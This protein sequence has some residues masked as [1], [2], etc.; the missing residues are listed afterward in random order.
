MLSRSHARSSAG[1]TSSRQQRRGALTTRCLPSSCVATHAGPLRPLPT[2]ASTP[3]A[4]SS[5]SSSPAPAPR[6]LGLR[7][8]DVLLA[9]LPFLGVSGAGAPAPA[10]ADEDGPTEPPLPVPVIRPELTPDQR[11]YDPSDPELRE[12]AAMLQRAL[13]APNVEAEEAGW[14]EVIE[15][16]GGLDR[17][18]VPDVVGRAWGNRGNARSRQGKL[19]EALSDYNTAIAI[20]PWSVDPVLN[21]GVALEALGRWEEAI[22]DYRAVLAAA[23]NDPAGWNNLGNAS[24]GLGRWEE[25]VEYYG[26]AAQLS[27][28]F[29]FAAAN[30][31][32][33]LFEVGRTE[34]A[35]R[36][37]R[38]LL[39]RYPDFADMRAALTGALWS[40]GKEGEAESQWERVDDP[41]YRDFAW[42]RFN[43]RW[44]PK[45]YKSL[46][47]FLQLRSLPAL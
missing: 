21:R 3:T 25:A 43:R 4:S 40:I 8:R 41:R 28:T 33:A 39:R 12:A 1:C 34:E 37:M 45:L 18:W 30:R 35:I 14:T 32:V 44:P 13:N 5:P 22:S 7:R 31:A 16:F 29:S 46:D 23:P 38:S 19:Q 47:A 10:R 2:A 42:L 17:P 36:E 26:R 6:G 24:G 11:K 27:P 20:C 9:L 15:R